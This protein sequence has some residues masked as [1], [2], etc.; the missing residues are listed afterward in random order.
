MAEYLPYPWHLEQYQQLQSWH[1]SE[2]L[3][4]AL[5]FK[6]EPGI[7][8]MRLAESFLRYLLCTGEQDFACGQCKACRLLEAGSHPNFKSLRLQEKAQQIKVDQVREV[9]DFLN[10]TAQMP[11]AKV[12]LIEPSEAMNTSAANALL[13]SLEEPSG[14]ALIILISH[15][16]E[17]LLPTIRSRCQQIALVKPSPE[18]ADT[19]LASFIKDDAKR[20]NLLAL[21]AFNP[22]Q[23]LAFEDQNLFELQ[24]TFTSQREAYAKGQG[25]VVSFA[26]VLDGSAIDSVFMLSQQM[27][28]N[29]I[30]KALG[31][32]HYLPEHLA[33]IAAIKR[34]TFVINAYG[35]L[36]AIATAQQD[37]W[38]S[39]PNSLLQLEALELRWQALL[40]P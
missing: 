22:L 5:L 34:P 39:N 14:H 3:P 28:Q 20:K 1:R 8:K 17:R 2:R 21:A 7:G 11:G 40:K 10:K 33:T 35:L 19:W 25:D 29:L 26:K 18:N 23:A 36:D 6:G 13:K 15:A 37:F 12:L 9:V 32:S 24:Q 38:L 4:H 27:L 16:P 30:K 31:G